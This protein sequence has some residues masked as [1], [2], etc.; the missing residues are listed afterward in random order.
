VEYGEWKLNEEEY[1][2]SSF[3]VDLD[4][5]YLRK[6]EGELDIERL[7][8]WDFFN[9]LEMLITP[10][11]NNHLMLIEC[12]QRFSGPGDKFS[13]SINSGFLTRVQAAMCGDEG[14]KADNERKC[15]EAIER[16]HQEG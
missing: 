11:Y 2:E 14:R 1:G 12:L 13:T 16:E 8:P 4:I 6:Y 9:G 5:P 3:K 7:K 15:Q 10:D